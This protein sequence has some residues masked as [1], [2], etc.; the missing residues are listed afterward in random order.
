M[1]APNDLA[2]VAELAREHRLAESTIWLLIRRYGLVRYRIPAKGKATHVSRA[3]FER[4]RRQPVLV[5]AAKS[6]A[7]RSP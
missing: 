1:S 6:G 4:A 3:D 7:N 2:T 5:A